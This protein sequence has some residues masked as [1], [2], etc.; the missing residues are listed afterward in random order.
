MAYARRTSR[1]AP[2]RHR[3]LDP[4]RE[5]NLHH[6]TDGPAKG[7]LHTHGL[8]AHGRPELEMRNVP[9]FLGAA[10]AELLNDFADDL[11]ND[12]AAPLLANQLVQW[13]SSSIRVVEGRPDANAGYDPAHY[14]GV[15]LVL[16]D[17]PDTG[18]ACD[19]C[20]TELAGRSPLP[21]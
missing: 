17:P 11:L 13:G 5:I 16:V 15:R 19:S 6:V 14:D 1:S 4:R 12:A 20:A 7:W 9:L 21:S 8:A 18:C 10:A 2:L 3:R